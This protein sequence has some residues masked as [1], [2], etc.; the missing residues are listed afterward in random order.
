M[1]NEPEDKNVKEAE[2][3]LICFINEPDFQE[4]IEIDDFDIYFKLHIANHKP[5]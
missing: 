1:Y 2:S 5:G 3:K 4:D